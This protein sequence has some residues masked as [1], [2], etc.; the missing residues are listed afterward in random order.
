MC[1]VDA[2]SVGSVSSAS[3]F[4]LLCSLP[5]RVSTQRVRRRRAVHTTDFLK[6]LCVDYI[7]CDEP[8]MRSSIFVSARDPT[9][10]SRTGENRPEERRATILA[11]LS[12]SSNARIERVPS[13]DG[14]ALQHACCCS[15]ISPNRLGFLHVAHAEWRRDSTEP[16]FASPETAERDGLV[17]YFFSRERVG[18]RHPGRGGC[19]G[20]QVMR[21][22]QSLRTYQK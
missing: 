11:R 21:S 22:L 15:V 1:G 19:H 17:P 10:R 12:V 9:M 18:E 4:P 14:V 6:S 3:E 13:D 7:N 8:A 2:P 5:V 20:M 16:S